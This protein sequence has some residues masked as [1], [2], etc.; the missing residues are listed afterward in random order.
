MTVSTRIPFPLA[1]RVLTC[2]TTRNRRLVGFLGQF[3]D[4]GSDLTSFFEE[5][6]KPGI[7]RRPRIVGPNN[8]LN[9]GDKASL[10]VQ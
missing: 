2:R 3:D 9:A 4:P 8:A 6:Y 7:G 10:D 1:L 5:Y